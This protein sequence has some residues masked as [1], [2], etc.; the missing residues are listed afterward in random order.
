MNSHIPRT[1]MKKSKSGGLPYPV[2]GLDVRLVV[3]TVG[4]RGIDRSIEKSR[5]P[6]NTH[7]S[8]QLIFDKYAKTN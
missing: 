1:T 4:D 2:S 8:S 7:K 5:E 3:E 6:R